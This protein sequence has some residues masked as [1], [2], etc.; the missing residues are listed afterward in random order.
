MVDLRDTLADGADLTPLDDCW[1][2]IGVH[3]D[4]SCARLEEHVHCR[5]CPVHAAAAIRLLDRY[6][7]RREAPEQSAVED[8]T[9]ERGDTY[10]IFRLG[11]EWLGLRT[12][13]L[14]EVTPACPVHSLPH[15]RSPALMGVANVR[16]ALVAC[17]SLTELLGLAN[18]PAAATDDPRRPPRMLTLATAD[19]SI[20]APVDEVEGIHRIPLPASA[21]PLGTSPRHTRALTRWRDRSVRLLDHEALLAAATRSLA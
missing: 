18:A 19:G 14:V 12:L 3:G 8:E 16:G 20:L 11:Q 7:L 9:L 5:N 10:L 15:Q 21:N 1:N 6:S 17:L 13:A 2:R 4:K